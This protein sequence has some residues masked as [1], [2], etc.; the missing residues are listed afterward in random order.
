VTQSQWKLVVAAELLVILVLAAFV[1]GDD[2]VLAVDPGAPAA[3]TDSRSSTLAS[4][5]LT[6]PAAMDVPPPPLPVARRTEVVAKAVPGD[7]VGILLR[8]KLR[9]SDGR[10]VARPTIYLRQ[11]GIVR[12]RPAAVGSVGAWAATG[13]QPGEWIVTVRAD[14]F[15]TLET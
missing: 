9:S 12:G 2:Q 3:P 14:G 10:A 7:P 6:A 11:P 4:A 8:G 15:A 5:G 1:R 13:L